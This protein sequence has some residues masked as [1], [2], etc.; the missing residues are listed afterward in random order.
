[1]H[2]LLKNDEKELL[3]IKILSEETHS[4]YSLKVLVDHRN[5]KSQ[6]VRENE[7]ERTSGSQRNKRPDHTAVFC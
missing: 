5:R 3:L 1:M 2:T 6:N 4:N 7:T